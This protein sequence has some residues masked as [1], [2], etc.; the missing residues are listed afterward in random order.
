MT[1]GEKGKKSHFHCTDNFSHNWHSWFQSY[2]KAYSNIFNEASNWWIS[3]R[4]E[5]KRARKRN[6]KENRDK[7]KQAD[8]ILRR[9]VDYLLR[10]QFFSLLV[11]GAFQIS[12]QGMN[13]G[14]SGFIL[15]AI[16][17]WELISEF[18]FFF[19]PLEKNS[20]KKY[21]DKGFKDNFVNSLAKPN[22]GRETV[23]G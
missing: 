10:K 12:I 8:I 15:M 11:G 22:Q 3:Q 1:M 9:Y 23:T 20:W 6:E 21:E 14:G 19:F 16:Y 7:W 4:F 13:S 5:E 18:F 2:K 17:I